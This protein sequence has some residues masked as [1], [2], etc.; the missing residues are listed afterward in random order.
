V[1]AGC[2]VLSERVFPDANDFPALAAELAVDAAVSGRVGLAFAVPKGAVGFRS[3]VALGAA[4]PETS[5]DEDGDFLLGKREVG[6]S[7]QRKM[8]SPAG[9]LVLPQ[10]REQR[11]FGLLVSPPPNKGH[12]FRAFFARPNI[13]HKG[14]GHDACCPCG[15]RSTTNP[16]LACVR[17]PG[18]TACDI[19]MAG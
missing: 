7:R 3:G 19:R 16:K 2:G 9:D 13:S 18:Q 11:L 4:V 1:Y 15:A 10:H 12:Y 5:V 14:C 8:P 6:L 17:S